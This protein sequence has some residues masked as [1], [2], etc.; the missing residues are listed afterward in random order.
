MFKPPD[1][2]RREQ[3]PQKYQKMSSSFFFKGHIEGGSTS[4][5]KGTQ[6]Q[7]NMKN[8]FTARQRHAS[9]CKFRVV[10]VSALR[11][12]M[13]RHNVHQKSF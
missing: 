6:H 1:I 10:D 12:P 11:A 4:L 13:P 8:I 5:E 3:N 7:T 9:T 2:P